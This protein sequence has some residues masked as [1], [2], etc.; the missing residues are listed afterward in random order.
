M[1][2]VFDKVTSLNV[3]FHGYNAIKLECICKT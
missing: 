1:S 3:N 2:R